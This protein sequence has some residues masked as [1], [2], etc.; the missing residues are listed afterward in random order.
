MVFNS[1]GGCFLLLSRCDRGRT[2]RAGSFGCNRAVA[3][4][5]PC[6]WCALVRSGH[7][8]RASGII[9]RN[10]P[11]CHVERF[12]RDVGARER[13]FRGLGSATSDSPRWPRRRWEPRPVRELLQWQ[14]LPLWVR[15]PFSRGRVAEAR[16][17]QRRRSDTCTPAKT[18]ARRTI[19]KSPTGWPAVNF[20]ISTSFSTSI[21]LAR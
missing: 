13:R 14:S 6:P 2:R 10:R 20:S 17:L 5:A 12:W 3:G 8:L 4:L 18:M 7:L 9:R 15:L 19:P 11:Q 16:R 21:M 1:S